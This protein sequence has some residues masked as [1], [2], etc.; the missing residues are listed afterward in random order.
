MRKQNFKMSRLLIA[1]LL[2]HN[3]LCAK[4]YDTL[5]N[6][7]YYNLDTANMRATVTHSDNADEMYVGNVVIPYCISHEDGVYSVSAV[8]DNAFRNCTEL[9]SVK[10]PS[11]ITYIGNYAFDGCINLTKLFIGSAVPPTLSNDSFLGMSRS[12]IVLYVPEKSMGIYKNSNLYNYKLWKDVRELFETVDGVYYKFDKETQQAIV[13]QGDVPYTG[14]VVIASKVIYEGEEYTVSS[15]AENSFYNCKDCHSVVIP[16]S[17]KSIGRFAFTNCG[18]YRFDIYI[19]SL[20]DWCNITIPSSGGPAFGGY[21]VGNNFTQFPLYHLFLNGEEITDLV[22]PEGITEIKDNLF[23][24]LSVNSVV[25]SNSVK[26]IGARAF[27]NSSI[28]SITIPQSLTSIKS[29]AFVGC[30]GLQILH[31]SDISSW[32]KCS[33]ECPPFYESYR[34]YKCFVFLENSNI[35]STGIIVPNEISTIGDNTFYGWNTIERFELPH[36]L[37]KIGISAFQ[38]CSSLIAINIPESVT[39]LGISAFQGC[40]NLTSANIPQNLATIDEK[41]FYLCTNLQSITIPESVKRIKSWAFDKCTNLMS[42]SLPMTLMELADNAFSNT[43]ILDSQEEGF[44]YIDGWCLGYKGTLDSGGTLVIK[45]GTRRLH[46]SETMRN[47]FRV[48]G[49]I[50]IPNSVSGELSMNNLNNLHTILIGD[51]IENI[52]NVD[53]SMSKELKSV[54]LGKGITEIP[55]NRFKDLT[56]LK[57]IAMSYNMRRIGAYAFQGC[58]SLEKVRIPNGVQTIGNNAFSDCKGMTTLTIPNSVTSIGSQAFSNC[59]SLTSV[60]SLITIPKTIEESVFACTETGY[61]K[62][63]IY[64]VA[65]LYVPRGRTTIYNNVSAWK[66]FS[67]KEEKDEAYEL[68]YVID[69]EVYKSI[70]IQPGITITPEPAPVKDGYVF[71]GWDA[72]PETMPSHDVLIYGR[73]ESY[74]GGANVIAN[75]YTRVYGEPNPQFGYDVT[76]GGISGTPII[77]CNATSQSPVGVYDITIERG[78][79]SE[80]NVSFISGTLTITKA[81]LTVTA[82]NA[83]KQEGEDNPAFTI[84]Y[85]GWKNGETENV[86]TTKPSATTTATKTSPAGEYNITVSGGEAQNYSFTYVNGKLTV[87]PLQSITVTANDLTMEYGDQVPTLTYTATGG[88]LTGVPSL[89]CSATSTSN[90]GTYPI[91]VTEGTVTNGNVTYVGGT[92]TITKAPLTV[93]A[94]NATKQEGEDNPAFTINYSGWKNGETESVLITMPTAT[95]TAT[96]DSPV[97]EYDITVSGGEAQ[98]YAFTYVNGKLTVTVPDGINDVSSDLKFNIYTTTGLLVKRDTT[99]LN[100]M[101]KGVYIV[102]GTKVVVK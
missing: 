3:V 56:K 62:R 83:T 17:I 7:V 67:S 43:G 78:S 71:S 58:E 51:G 54:I 16:S 25:I 65:T 85:S 84:N 101:P 40:S 66:L 19:D 4:A 18:E 57:T 90:T 80:G 29:K 88:S 21:Q 26:T 11:T 70:D 37:K 81:P 38:N 20:W 93:T 23:T 5:I 15:I 63:T 100:G 10:L 12:N 49:T 92:L 24:S 60:N 72:V 73:F 75:S 34:N 98:N 74:T 61:D 59:L 6:G 99:T 91:T 53:F 8:G 14:D 102:N 31:L 94:V 76:N 86:L 1:V 46:I 55:D 42:V 87:T 36:N 48:A 97:G 95:T 82:A 13:T 52:T 9:L 69:G 32:C 45:D 39:S 68:T 47:A 89:A 27:M 33:I 77:S 64:Y 50:V 28:R 44:L 41:T 2:A 35:L 30:K 79:V 96:K 22:I